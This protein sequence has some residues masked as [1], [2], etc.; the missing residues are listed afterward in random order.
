MTD[1][2]LLS[3]KILQPSFFGSDVRI[4]FVAWSSNDKFIVP[5]DNGLLDLNSFEKFDAQE[6]FQHL[7]LII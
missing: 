6:C 3:S 7:R 2:P 4:R 5:Y 1:I